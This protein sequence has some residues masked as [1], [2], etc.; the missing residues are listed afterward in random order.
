MEANSLGRR[1]FPRLVVSRRLRSLQVLA[2][3]NLDDQSVA[4]L[5]AEYRTVRQL[6]HYPVAKPPVVADQ[7]YLVAGLQV[8]KLIVGH[9][10]NPRSQSAH[11]PEPR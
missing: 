1:L 7:A 10:A 5:V 9:S 8:D 4:A 3:A 2:V 6:A 11:D